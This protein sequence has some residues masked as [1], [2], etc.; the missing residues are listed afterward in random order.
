MA[1]VIKDRV[2]EY[3]TTT[4]TGTLTLAGT[5][6][7]YQQ[8]AVVG[9]GNTTYYTIVA[10]NGDWESGIGTYTSSGTILARTTVLSSSNSNNLVNFAAGT[11][12]VF[13]SQPAGRAVAV[14]TLATSTSLGTSN[15]LAPS[16]NA[17]KGYVDN[18]TYPA[19]RRNLI[20]NPTFLIN[21]R[22]AGD[23]YVS[24]NNTFSADRWYIA[25]SANNVF[26]SEKRTDMPLTASG[27]ISYLKNTARTIT[28]S[29][30]AGYYA[31]IT[32]AIEGF[33][34]NS[35]LFG[36]AAAKNLMLSFKAKCSK[37]GTYSVALTNT[38]NTLSYISDYTITT[39]DTWQDFV[40]SIPGCTTGTW[41]R[42]NTTGAR[43][44][45]S[46]GSGTTYKTS[47]KDTWISGNYT[48]SSTATGLCTHGSVNDTLLLTEIQLE[49]GTFK[50][51]FEQ[52]PAPLYLLDCLRYFEALNFFSQNA[53][54]YCGGCLS[55]MVYKRATP[56]AYS[57]RNVSGD[58]AVSSLA[59][60]SVTPTMVSWNHNTGYVLGT[61][62]V[63]SDIY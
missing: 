32:Q 52:L 41:S 4:G 14:D 47:T 46:L 55:Y 42:A 43:L 1:F 10:E 50:T 63:S 28:A 33:S 44:K 19:D 36:T 27:S 25:A 30:A 49:V 45:F 9:N 3:T 31:L 29:P 53:A 62:F 15:L 58:S 56:T 24:T 21:N 18:R 48:Q 57:F 8:F 17:V 61:I 16:Q 34:F 26:S 60:Q 12:E 20:H 22:N 59:F 11:K 13:S 2:F 37:T 54:G 35:A 5:K 38:D 40:I 23:L 6:S 51:P 7:G 39:A